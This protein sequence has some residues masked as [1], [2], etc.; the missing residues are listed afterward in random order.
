MLFLYQCLSSDSEKAVTYSAYI[1]CLV[2]HLHKGT[3]GLGGNSRFDS[4]VTENILSKQSV[5][6]YNHI[7]LA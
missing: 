1:L 7:N 3:K 5:E 4:D 2:E 6:I